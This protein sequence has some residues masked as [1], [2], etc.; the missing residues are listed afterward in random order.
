MNDEEMRE[1]LVC[2]LF[3]RLRISISNALIG[4]QHVAIDLGGGGG[5][6]VSSSDFEFVD[7]N[8]WAS[9]SIVSFTSWRNWMTR[10]LLK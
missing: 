9:P 10:A 2:R 8:M 3:V 4:M 1:W 7:N 5:R 6:K